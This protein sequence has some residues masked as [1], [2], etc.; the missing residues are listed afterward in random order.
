MDDDK[1]QKYLEYIDLSEIDLNSYRREPLETRAE[2]IPQKNF[3]RRNDNGTTSSEVIY[4]RENWKMVPEAFEEYLKF[5]QDIS[6]L[7]ARRLT[8]E[9]VSVVNGESFR[10]TDVFLLT[11]ALYTTGSA[12][13]IKDYS[14]YNPENK[15][16]EIKYVLATLDKNISVKYANKYIEKDGKVSES[17]RK[18]EDPIFRRVLTDNEAEEV[19]MPDFMLQPIVVG[20]GQ[21]YRNDYEHKEFEGVCYNSTPNRSTLNLLARL[22]GIEQ[23]QFSEKYPIL[24]SKFKQ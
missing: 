15:R 16:I 19:P 18:I 17:F 13:G 8:D 11:L 4:T 3:G 22:T 2:L 6:S 20:L 12:L 10:G 21:V 14:T 1:I 23:E 7:S 5:V 24:S 9:D